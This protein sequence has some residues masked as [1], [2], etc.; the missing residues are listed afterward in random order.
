LQVLADGVGQGLARLDADPPG[1][2]VHGQVDR[3][4]HP[5]DPPGR[6]LDG[7]HGAGQREVAV[8]TGDLLDGESRARPPDREPDRGQ[9]F[10]RLQRGS[11]DHLEELG[12]RYSPLTRRAADHHFG[13][14]RSGHGGQFGCRVSVRQR[15]AER[16]A[17]ADLEMADVRSRQP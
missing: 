1:T 5:L 12:R 15:T 6:D 3:Q 8:P 11:E 16:A 17:A 14:Q 7:A 13:I 4:R 2:A 9:Q 10:F